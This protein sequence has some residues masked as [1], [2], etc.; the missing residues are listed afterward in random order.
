MNRRQSEILAGSASQKLT[1]RLKRCSTGLAATPLYDDLAS[2]VFALV[3]R[4]G[5]HFAIKVGTRMVWV[6][7]M[8]TT[9]QAALLACSHYAH[10]QDNDIWKLGYCYSCYNGNA[11]PKGTRVSRLLTRSFRLCQFLALNHSERDFCLRGTKLYLVEPSN[12]HGACHS[13]CLAEHNFAAI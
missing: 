6:H 3:S 10:R 7:K 4:A 12:L 11:A 5:L 9:S 1:K 8:Q 13:L 2:E